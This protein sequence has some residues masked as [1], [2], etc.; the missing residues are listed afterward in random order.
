MSP[1]NWNFRGKIAWSSTGRED[2]Q[3]QRDQ[4][5]ED[6]ADAAADQAFGE[7]SGSAGEILATE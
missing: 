5:A 4:T 1:F 6:S 7:F 3:D 2:I